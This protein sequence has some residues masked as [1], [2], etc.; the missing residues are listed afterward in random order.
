LGAVAG[1]DESLV[2]HGLVRV[3]GAVVGAAA[4]LPGAL[5]AL[6]LHRGWDS[7]W[8][9]AHGTED[10]APSSAAVVGRYLLV[11]V[12][13]LLLVI[14]RRPRLALVP[15]GLALLIALAGDTT[16][17][18]PLPDVPQSEPDLW[19]PP[20]VPVVAVE[21]ALTAAPAWLASFVGPRIAVP[22]E[23]PRALTGRRHRPRHALGQRA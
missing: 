3:P 19:L 23:R 5:F 10:W 12:P 6:T 16:V 15:F 2:R 7:Y 20:S 4:L 13:A 1:G 9:Q 8:A 11:A 18:A 22:P 14:D 21:L 17:L